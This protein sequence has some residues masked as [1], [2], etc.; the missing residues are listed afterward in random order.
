VALLREELERQGFFLDGPGLAIIDRALR[1]A[2]VVGYDS[3]I[4]GR[5]PSRSLELPGITLVTT[6][7]F[8]PKAGV[9]VGTRGSRPGYGSGCGRGFFSKRRRRWSRPGRPT[10]ESGEPGPQR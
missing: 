5:L 8:A 6:P 3:N 7:E 4:N 10:T 2:P 1:V 9:V